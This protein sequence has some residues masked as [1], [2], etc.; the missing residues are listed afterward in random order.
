MTLVPAR[1]RDAAGIAAMRAAAARTLTARYGSGPWSGEPTARWV[2]FRM[3]RESVLV[4]RARGRL[5]ATLVLCRTKPWSIDRSRFSRVA[6][7]LYLVEMAVDPAR[8]RRGV[9]RACLAAAERLARA[10][11]ADALFL[12][13]YDARAGAGGFYRACGYRRVGRAT[14]RG[15]PLV[16]WERLLGARRPGR[17][18]RP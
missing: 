1:A 18:G 3:R 4:A 11:G 16:Y 10:R 6:R 15:V 5:V 14:Y 12:D 2:R 9:G 7:P 13:S 8:Q 17:R